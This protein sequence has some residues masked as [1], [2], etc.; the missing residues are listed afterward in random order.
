MT[1]HRSSSAGTGV[2]V[3]AAALLAVVLAGCGVGAPPTRSRSARPP[4]RICARWPPA[5]SQGRAP[6]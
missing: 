2:V 4:R 1:D 6:N 5:T 3:I